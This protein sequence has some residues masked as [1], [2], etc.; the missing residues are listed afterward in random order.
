MRFHASVLKVRNK[1]EI[2]KKEFV[3]MRA[4]I[5]KTLLTVMMFIVVSACGSSSDNSNSAVNDSNTGLNDQAQSCLLY[6][7]PSPRDS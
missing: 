1:L 3:F 6:T 2:L 5:V 7:S 4:N